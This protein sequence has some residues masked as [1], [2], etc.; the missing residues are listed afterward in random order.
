MS[1]PSLGAVADAVGHSVL[2]FAF[3]PALAP[4]PR[5]LAFEL[6]NPLNRTDPV[7]LTYLP[8]R[9]GVL[10]LNVFWQGLLPGLTTGILNGLL[11]AM[12]AARTTPPLATSRAA[13]LGAA[14]GTA[15][16]MAMTTLFITTGLTSNAQLSQPTTLFELAIGLVCGAVAAPKAAQWLRASEA[17]RAPTRPA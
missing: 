16:A 15:A 14:T 12:L 4:V 8:V 13:L 6:Q 9:A 1:R 2:V 17:T 5:W 3:L 11:F 10:L 7:V